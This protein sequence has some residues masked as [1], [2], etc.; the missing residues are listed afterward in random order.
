MT[1]KLDLGI[2]QL[3]N[4]SKFLLTFD[5]FPIRSSHFQEV[6]ILHVSMSGALPENSRHELL[7]IKEIKEIGA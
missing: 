5:M 2:I 7:L 1:L 4:F 3:I 6:H